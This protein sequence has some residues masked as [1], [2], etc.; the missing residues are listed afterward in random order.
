[1][2]RLITYDNIR[3]VSDKENFKRYILNTQEVH[4]NPIV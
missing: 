3:L 4:K 1:M 2:I